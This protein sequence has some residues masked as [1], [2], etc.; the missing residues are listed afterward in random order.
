MMKC[1]FPSDNL[2]AFMRLP[3]LLREPSFNLATVTQVNPPARV[4]N[5]HVLEER[6]KSVV[7]SHLNFE[8]VFLSQIT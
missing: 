8:V 2:I 6:N 5:E 3:F 7:V 4:L 1:Q